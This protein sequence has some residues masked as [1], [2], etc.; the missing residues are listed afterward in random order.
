MAYPPLGTVD[1]GNGRGRGGTY[2][3]LPRTD[4]LGERGRG[5]TY[6]SVGWTDTPNWRDWR[7]RTYRRVG[8]IDAAN[9]RDRGKTHP[10][11]IPTSPPLVAARDGLRWTGHY[12]VSPTGQS[13]HAW[14]AEPAPDESNLQRGMRQRGMSSDRARHGSEGSAVSGQ[15]SGSGQSFPDLAPREGYGNRSRWQNRTA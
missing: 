1:A 12:A 7:G 11:G 15:P 4:A 2:P 9:W 13:S 3:P 10:P 14:S 5:A 6:P 8:S